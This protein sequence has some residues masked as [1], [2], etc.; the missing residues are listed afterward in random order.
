M[1]VRVKEEIMAAKHR[2][3]K[4]RLNDFEKS[5]ISLNKDWH[6]RLDD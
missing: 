2:K 6:I 3:I 4:E 5:Y 1:R